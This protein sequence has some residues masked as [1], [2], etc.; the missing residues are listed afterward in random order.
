MKFIIDPKIF[1]EHPNLKIGAITAKN[2]D[3][4]KRISAVESLLRGASMER[5]REFEKKGLDKDPRILR[6]REAYARFGAK[7]SSYPSSIEALIGRIVEGKEIPHINA[8]VDLYNYISLKYVIPVGGE[9]MD[10]FFGDL[11]LTYASGTECFRPINTVEIKQAK[12]GEIIYKDKGGV[13]VRRWNYRE[14]ERTKLTKDTRNSIIVMEDLNNISID[15]FEKMLYEFQDL[16]ERYIS[17]DVAVYILTED[18]NEIDLEIEGLKKADDSKISEK[19]KIFFLAQQ[20]LEKKAKK[21]ENKEMKKMET[22]S[23]LSKPKPPTDTGKSKSDKKNTGSELQSNSGLTSISGST[24]NL[25]PAS[26]SGS[27][28]NKVE[29]IN[30][31]DPDSYKEKLTALVKEVVGR[32]FPEEAA[33]LKIEYPKDGTHGDY[34][35]NVALQIGSRVKADPVKVAEE[36]MKA[37]E[38]PD[39]IEKMEV[40]GP[41]FINFYLSD[42]VFDQTI[43]TILKQG[44][45]YGESKI[46]KNKAV[47]MDY[48]S[49]NIAKP[50]GVH[51]LLSTIIGQSLYDIYKNRGF[52]TISVNHIGDW[53]TQFGKLIYAYRNWGDKE[54]IEKDPIPELLKIYVKFHDEAERNS[55]LE[56]KAREEFKKLE[57]D[58]EENKKLWKWIVDVSLKA[59]QKTYDKLGGIHFDYVTGESFYEDKM[60]SVIDE[61][62]EKGVFVEGEEGSLIVEFEDE[63]MAPFVIR[64]LD[65]A[66]LYSTRDLATFKYR[67][68]KFDPIKIIYVVDVAQSLHFKQ[69]FE[70]SRRLGWKAEAGEHVHFGRMNLPDG[71]MSTRKGNVILLDEVLD[72]A[73]KRARQVIEE[74]SPNLAS[75][76]DAARIIGISAVKYNILSQNRISDII[77]EWDK[78]LSLEGNSAPY[79]QYSYARAKSILRKAVALIESGIRGAEN[80]KPVSPKRRRKLKEPKKE[81]FSLFEAIEH[82]DNG[83][84]LCSDILP[85]PENAEERETLFLRALSKYGEY[86][87]MTAEEN[88][89]NLLANYLYDLSQKFNSFYNSV[90]VIKADKEE[91]FERRIN[92]V[93]AA[94]Q[95]LKNGLALLQVEVL[96]EM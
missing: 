9:D 41:G 54:T 57:N 24:S 16:V 30:F 94:A 29:Q 73:V 6:W 66:T 48:S 64:K 42:E 67:L 39:Y 11:E 92:I 45:E 35:T 91:K 14:A 78:M 93:K 87:A 85:D 47:V 76:D 80:T 43:A 72:E 79:M 62:I 96:E 25:R 49:P 31:T 22:I 5:S 83:G 55:E 26:N 86:V 38:K 52:T 65:C 44:D 46:G 37:I 40:A 21:E 3:N 81:Q 2:I 74:K 82:L 32:K 13:V 17:G 28:P 90:P 33:R 7:P 4:S 84:D 23:N 27:T 50:L 1:Q 71:N 10:K 77:F 75:K 60:Q 95:V 59:I 51:H 70:T 56:E 58:D 63:N 20:K 18:N 88:K 12:P 8:L 89:P 34:A 36:L 15:E 19:E 69:L 53:G 68:E 61:G